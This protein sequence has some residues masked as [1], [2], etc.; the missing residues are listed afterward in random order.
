MLSRTHVKILV[1]VLAAA[2]IVPTATPILDG[3]ATDAVGGPTI[4]VVHTPDADAR[5]VADQV[6]RFATDAGLDLT[7]REVDGADALLSAIRGSDAAKLVV[8]G[9]GQATDD[10]QAGVVVDGDQVGRNRIVDAIEASD[11]GRFHFVACD[12]DLP[13]TVDGRPVDDTEGTIGRLVAVVDVIAGFADVTDEETQEA[14]TPALEATVQR[15]GGEQAIIEDAVAPEHP[16]EMTAERRRNCDWSTGICRVEYQAPYWRSGLTP[17]QALRGY[18]RLCWEEDPDDG[19]EARYCN[20]TREDEEHGLDRAQSEGGGFAQAEEKFTEHFRDW[21]TGDEVSVG[22]DTM[23][24]H[25]R[26]RY[27]F[28][29]QLF[30]EGQI[31]DYGV[32]EDG[33]TLFTVKRF[34]M[35]ALEL[36][37]EV[38]SLTDN[39]E[40]EL[41]LLAFEICGSAYVGIPEG[42]DD[43]SAGGTIWGQLGGSGELEFEWGDDHD[44]FEIGGYVGMVGKMGL[45]VT[46]EQA[47]CTY[48][49]HLSIDGAFVAVGSLSYLESGV[50]KTWDVLDMSH[51]FDR[52]G[53]G[54]RSTGFPLDDTGTWVTPLYATTTL[55]APDLAALQRSPGLADRL[56]TAIGRDV[57]EL[58]PGTALDL[59][60]EAVCQ[61]LHGDDATCPDARYDVGLPEGSATAPDAPALPGPRAERLPSVAVPKDL[62]AVGPRTAP[63]TCT[64]GAEVPRDGPVPGAWARACVDASDG[65]LSAGV[66][67]GLAGAE[68]TDTVHDAAGDP[69]SPTWWTRRG[70]ERCPPGN[71]LCRPVWSGPA[72]P[73]TERARLSRSVDI[74]VDLDSS[75]A[76]AAV[77]H[78]SSSQSDD[79]DR[80]G[81]GYSLADPEPMSPKEWVGSRL[82]RQI[83]GHDPGGLPADYACWQNHVQGDD[84]GS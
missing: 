26:Q 32:C 4:E 51:R 8:V 6:E 27:D 52:C 62:T 45:G 67:G 13:E 53:D 31:N 33:T 2:M 17:Y 65:L 12:L 72:G 40:F 56:S 18:P 54:E 58:A 48:R 20:W 30:F 28:L 15:L 82:A 3:G 41:D 49:L 77:T 63:G 1:P 5:F 73:V 7:V 34:A 59:T 81:F 21:I 14:A 75:G 46:Q 16:L 24:P 25:D 36:A 22:W 78:C 68:I 37:T 66:S 44:L 71:D 69:A 23:G 74:L 80:Y 38:D 19:G 83:T 42:S 43:G 57:T 55:D 11:A 9:H 70:M 84:C 47:G 39:L 10:G 76:S 64:V 50:S 35:P 60:D 61:A 29:L 79:C